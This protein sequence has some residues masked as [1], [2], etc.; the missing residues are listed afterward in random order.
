MDRRTFLAAS[1]AGVGLMAAGLSTAA[2]RQATAAEVPQRILIKGG[3]VVT[4]EGQGILRDTDVLI[5]HGSIVAIGK[6]LSTEQADIVDARNMI[7]L[8][9]LVD[10]H[11]HCWQGAIRNIAVDTD[12]S[13]YFGD[14]LGHLA[15]YYRPEDVYAGTLSSNTE[16]LD[17]GITTVYDWAH[18]M[19]SPEHADEAIRAHRESGIRAVFGYGF[20]NISPAWSYESTKALPRDEVTRVRNTYFSANDGILTMGLA[21]RGP[22]YMSTFDVTRTDWA[23]ALDLALPVSVH[24]GLGTGG[25]KYQAIR[26]M[27]AAGLLLEGANY[28]HCVTLSAKDR[29][30]I[31]DSGG[32][33]I[34]TPAIEMTMGFGVPAINSTLAAGMRPGLGS[35]VVTTTGGDL[36]TQMRAAHQ[37]ARMQAFT[38]KDK[39]FVPVTAADVLRFATID[40][41]RA[42]GLDSKIG[43]LKTGKRADVILL[44]TDRLSFSP[45]NDPIGAIVST[46]TAADVDTVIVNGVI[47]KRAG[48]LTGIDAATVAAKA[49][50]SGKYLS[51]KL[52][53]S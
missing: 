13:G 26:R 3:T 31:H 44:R 42:L 43:S 28:V 25:I 10:A 33:C 47:K 52:M 4:V 14:V 12:L 35:D 49:N 5:E 19:N 24:V 36:F 16:A 18:I 21:L 20:P 46:A 39:N 40:G 50:A 7:V 38:E 2:T 48:M 29:R 1:T 41:A 53:R 51:A 32:H 6:Q 45:L 11:R 34:S 30:R 27:A 37:V 8:P 15:P 23:L 9:G 17:A 22:E